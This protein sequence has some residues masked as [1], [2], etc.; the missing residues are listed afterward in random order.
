MLSVARSP[1]QFFNLW[2]AVKK[3]WE[4]AGEGAAA[5]FFETEYCSA[6]WDSWFAAASGFM[7]IANNNNPIEADR[8][9]MKEHKLPSCAQKWVLS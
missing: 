7:G 3:E 8:H 1:S 5:A 2:A 4:L 6:P 9:K